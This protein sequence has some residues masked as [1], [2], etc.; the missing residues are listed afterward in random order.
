MAP[1]VNRAP[2]SLD[3]GQTSEHR[4]ERWENH[5]P[6]LAGRAGPWERQGLEWL[7]V[8]VAGVS[9]SGDSWHMVPELSPTWIPI[10]AIC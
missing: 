8:G 5:L 4:K 3:L 10:L 7:G 2:L 9:R 6:S 1:A